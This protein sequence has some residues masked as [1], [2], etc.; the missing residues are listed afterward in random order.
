MDG[1]KSV[2]RN[3]EIVYSRVLMSLFPFQRA[4]RHRGQYIGQRRLR[5]GFHLGIAP[6]LYGMC[7]KNG[8]RFAAQG[9]GLG[10]ARLRKLGGG[11]VGG[12]D[13]AVFKI[14]DVMHTA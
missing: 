2:V 10:D 1:Q 9:P 12:R 13:P 14:Y 6:V 11:H 8:R 7:Y 5:H 3:S 4:S